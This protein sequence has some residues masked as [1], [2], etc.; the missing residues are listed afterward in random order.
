[1]QDVLCCDAF[2][3]LSLSTQR[4][5]PEKNRCV[6]KNNFTYKSMHLTIWLAQLLREESVHIPEGHSPQL[7]AAFIYH[8]FL[9]AFYLHGAKKINR[10]A[11]QIFSYSGICNSTLM[12]F[13]VHL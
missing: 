6:Q 11:V 4:V 7:S 10:T 9:Y 3:K 1:M 13:G 5:F 12:L 2:I 8:K